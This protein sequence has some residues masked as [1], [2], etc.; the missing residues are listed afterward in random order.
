MT[1][2]PVPVV[3]APGLRSKVRSACSSTTVRQ[4][5]SFALSSMVLGGLGMATSAVLARALTVDDYASYSFS[6]QMLL[7]TAMFFEFGLFLPAAR[8]AAA[9]GAD[10][11]ERRRVTGAAAVLFVPVSIAFAL[12]VHVLS[13]GVDAFFGVQAGPSLRLVA[14]A[15]MG[16]PLDFVCLQ[17][18]QGL[19][20]LHS[21]A[22][23]AVSSKLCCLVVLAT[24][25]ASGVRLTSS[26]VLLAEALS[27]L[28]GWVTLLAYLRPL[29]RGLREAL[30]CLVRDAREYAF[31]V[32][33]GRVLSMGTYH[34]DTLMLGALSDPRSFACYMI[35]LSLAYTVGLPGSGLATALFARLARQ[36]RLET[37]WIVAVL[38]VSAVPA[39]VLSVA[40][41]PLV[42]LVFS[43]EF[44]PAARLMPVVAAAQ[45]INAVTRLFN[46]F[47]AA[48]ALGK[49]LRAAAIAL[50]LSNLVL[51]VVLIPWFG[52]AGAAWASV[53]ALAVNLFVHIGRYRRAVA[54]RAGTV[55]VG[56]VAAVTGTTGRRQDEAT[57]R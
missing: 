3:L 48:H 10:V 19:G 21:Y 11:A 29:F 32:Y 36:P 46:T 16:Y 30:T 44:L 39:L 41:E 50:T 56:E 27:L 34:M 33:V 37:R 14:L 42:R 26:G 7:F 20:R 45:L 12:T 9:A 35:A 6:R 23:A 18:A 55:L 43:S 38:T 22:V 4:A 15:S 51:N 2:D 53:V 57:G 54:E 52:A 28:A 47:L 40:A 1:T 8:R 17:L 49:D 31:S 24:M 25:V 5:A 13:W